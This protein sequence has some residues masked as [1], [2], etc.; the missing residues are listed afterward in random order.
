MKIVL[1][2]IA[3]SRGVLTADYCSRFVG[4]YIACPPGA[5]CS[6]VVA[7]NGGPLPRETALLFDSLNA[8]FL[9]R[10]NDEGWDISA[11]QQIARSIPCD[12]LVCLGESVYFHRPGWLRKMVEAWNKFGAGMYGFWASYLVRPHL[13]TTGFV[14]DPVHLGVYPTVRNHNERY[15]FEHGEHAMW[16]HIQSLSRPVKLVTWDGIY[17]PFQ[18]RTPRDILWRGTQLNCLAFCSHTDR[19]RAADAETKKKWSR[20]V[21]QPFRP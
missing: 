10:L 1:A 17:D 21:D 19:F 16:R 7:C 3:V 2:Y 20:W 14:V 15:Q 8:K 4:S 6:I 18:W 11:Y 13:N 5:E 9:P 12:M